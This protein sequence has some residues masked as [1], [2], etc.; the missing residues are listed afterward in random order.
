MTGLRVPYAMAL[1]KTIPFSK[2]LSHLSKQGIPVAATLVQLA[3]AIVMIFV[4]GFNTLTDLL[5]F[6]IWI[7]Y[8]MTFAATIILRK[9]EPDMKRPYKTLFY[10]VTPIIAI[11]GGIF[12]V[13]STLFTQTGL[14]LIGLGI[15]LI[16]LPVYWIA[17]KRN[18]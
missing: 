4:G 3:I 6:V 1:D 9:R 17:K 15:T 18:G 8:T 5:V 14:A 7:F 11:I 2:Q 12:I 16:G 13:V 10:P